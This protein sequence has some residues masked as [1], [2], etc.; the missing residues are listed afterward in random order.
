[1]FKISLE[2]TLNIVHE[3]I[4]KDAIA[5]YQ[6]DHNLMKSAYKAL[7]KAEGAPGSPAG[8]IDSIFGYE[9]TLTHQEFLIACEKS[10][11]SWLFRDDY[12]RH[13]M[14]TTFGTK[15]QLENYGF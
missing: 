13:K 3:H 11:N 12:I 6:Y 10:Q 5:Y 9:S 15:E 1:M 2:C 4:D 8:I 7:H 14:K